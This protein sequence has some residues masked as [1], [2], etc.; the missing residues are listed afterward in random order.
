MFTVIAVAGQRSGLKACQTLFG[1]FCEQFAVKLFKQSGRAK[2]GEMLSTRFG[3]V[4]RISGKAFLWRRRE[5]FCDMFGLI[6]RCIGIAVH[7]R[8]NCY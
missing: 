2:I 4:L 5:D 8:Y 6:G 3:P 7:R 1:V